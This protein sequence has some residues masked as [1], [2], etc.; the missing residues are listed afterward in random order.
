MRANNVSANTISANTIYGSV[1]GGLSNSITFNTGNTNIEGSPFN[2]LKS[3]T[4]TIPEQFEHLENYD[5]KFPIW[6]ISEL[7]T[8]GMLSYFYSDM[9]TQDQK[10]IARQYNTNY[11]VLGSWLRCCTDA[12]NIYAHY[13]RLYYRVFTAAPSGFDLPESVRH[14]AWAVM[15]V[16]KSLYPSHDKWLTEFMPH[17]EAIMKKYKNEISLYHLAF[18]ENWNEYLNK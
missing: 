7:F 6:V 18:P 4:I 5:G 17:M 11:R 8:F 1:V 12:R 13:G 10:E 9:L 15:L 16:I 14:R 2:G 3:C